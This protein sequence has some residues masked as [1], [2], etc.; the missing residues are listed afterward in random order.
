M[1]RKNILLQFAWG[2][3]LQGAVYGQWTKVAPGIDYRDMTLPGPVRVFIARADRS[4]HTWTVDSMTSMGTIKGGRETVPDM[5]KRYDDTVTFDGRRYEVKVA[6]NGDYFNAGTGYVF[7]GQIMAGWF[8]KRYGSE[9]YG[10]SGFVWTADRKC[11]IGGD[12]RNSPKIQQ[13]VFSDKAEMNINALNDNREKD[14]LAL[15]TPQY[16]ST[17]GTD[18]TGVEVLVRV[19]QPV[20]VNPKPPGVRGEILKVR[21]NAGSTPMPFDCVVL[22]AT[23]SAAPMLL[24]HAK[25][26]GHV[27]INLRLED[28]G[29]E[30]ISLKPAQW[31]HPWGSIGDT[32]NLLIDG[33]IPKHWEAKAAKYAAQGQK[34]G[35]VVKDPRTAIAHNKN[36][37]YFIVIDGRTEESIGMT[38][39]QT[40]EFC[41]NELKADNAV[42]QDGGG[43]STLWVDGKVKNVPSDRRKND[44]NDKEGKPGV[45]RGVANGYLIALVHPPKFSKVLKPGQQVEAQGELELRL[46][47]GTQYGSAG[48]VA[49]GATGQILKHSL[50][51]VYAK[52]TN[53][54]PVRFGELEGWA[55]NGSL[56]AAR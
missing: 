37:V 21:E 44:K 56:T 43:S 15:Y 1:T 32:Q 7:G 8:V 27:Y 20:G 5:A 51:G 35:S 17:T 29:S 49:S 18:N 25:S 4:K 24:Q 19:N 2:L 50:D 23:G 11:F 42:M 41:K 40:A 30:R 52:G 36:F 33:Y 12:V 55:P 26:G 6:I 34:H 38:F 48:K 28:I 14:E 45:P 16:D 46:G 39:T 3:V 13:V 47:P 54:W 22:S 9:I 31:D 10:L 53:W